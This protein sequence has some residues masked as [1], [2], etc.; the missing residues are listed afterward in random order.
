MRSLK[1]P[2]NKIQ[3]ELFVCSIEEPVPETSSPMAQAEAILRLPAEGKD[4]VSL[5]PT[6]LAASLSAWEGWPDEEAA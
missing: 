1:A 4:P 2:S 3:P 6:S 5:T